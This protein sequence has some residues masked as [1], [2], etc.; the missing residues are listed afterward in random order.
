MSDTKVTLKAVA[1]SDH[2]VLDVTLDINLE[3]MCTW[4][5]YK[6]QLLDLAFKTENI[7]IKKLLIDISK[8][9]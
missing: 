6:S 7:S 1:E 2:K 4:T 5:E 8:L 3:G 9:L